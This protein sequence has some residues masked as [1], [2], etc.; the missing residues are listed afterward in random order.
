MISLPAGVSQ[1]RN[2]AIPRHSNHSEEVVRRREGKGDTSGMV[3]DIGPK[4][5][6]R[7]MPQAR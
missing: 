3:M 4:A 1:A 2:R 6:Q 5:V 7:K